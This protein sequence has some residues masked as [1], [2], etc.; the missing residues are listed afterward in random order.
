[1]SATYEKKCPT[2][3]GRGHLTLYVSEWA[4]A[5]ERVRA[6]VRARLDRAKVRP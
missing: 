1:M 3:H 2:C 6:W 4:E 5:W